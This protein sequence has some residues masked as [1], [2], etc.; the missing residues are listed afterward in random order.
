MASL[1]HSGVTKFQPSRTVAAPPGL[2]VRMIETLS[3]W[4]RTI[5]SRRQLAEMSD[6]ELRDFG[7]TRIDVH[8]ELAKPFWRSVPPC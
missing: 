8:Q 6:R 2:F 1:A 3:R 4:H 7:A 5:H